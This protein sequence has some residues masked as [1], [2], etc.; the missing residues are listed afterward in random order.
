MCSLESYC[1]CHI[2]FI[3]SF[4][5]LEIEYDEE[6]DA[7]WCDEVQQVRRRLMTLYRNPTMCKDQLHA[8]PLLFNTTWFIILALQEA[9]FVVSINI[10]PT[11]VDSS[12]AV[13]FPTYIIDV[14]PKGHLS[15]WTVS[16]ANLFEIAAVL[17]AVSCLLHIYWFV[18]LKLSSLSSSYH[19]FLPTNSQQKQLCAFFFR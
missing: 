9:A 8:K 6:G 19:T 18:C 17:H 5:R 11:S 7:I 2:N 12:G 1:F 13:Q 16:Y 4:Y 15:S 3:V 10:V 14:H